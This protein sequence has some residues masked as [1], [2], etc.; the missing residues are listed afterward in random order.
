MP[1]DINSPIT[2]TTIKDIVQDYIL[3][4]VNQFYQAKK[5]EGVSPYT[6]K[7][8]KQQLGHF[9]RYCEAQLISRIEEITPNSIRQFL[10]WHG[11]TGHNPGG[12][13]AAFRVLRAFLIW[14]ENEVDLE[15]WKNPI[16]KVKA[17][18]TPVEFL[19][20]VEIEDVSI[21]IETCKPGSF[22]DFRDKAL[23]LFLLDTGA[24]AW[25]LLRIDLENVNPITGAVLICKG[26]GNKSR[27]VFIGKTS[28][29]GLRAYLKHRKDDN[30]A[31]WVTADGERLGYG[32]LRAAIAKRAKMAGVDTPSLHS[33][34]RAFALNMLRNGVDIFSLQKLMGH[35]DLSTLRRYLAQ[36]WDDIQAAHCLGSPVEKM[37]EKG[38]IQANK[39]KPRKGSRA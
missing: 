33:F 10:L 13:H 28:R 31:L 2:H 23:L 16:H 8:Y 32:G 20:P 3:D 29:K 39:I 35:S 24:R 15:G 5:V 21:L 18:K 19:Q 14:Y 30:I 26:K 37:K 9:L 6:L 11:E 36:N 1:Q 27:T 12:L 25:E 17:P 38:E 4:W 34:R 7:F 22:L